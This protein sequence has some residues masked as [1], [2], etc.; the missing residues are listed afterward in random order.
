M[1]IF[2]SLS[3]IVKGAL[4]SSE[5][6]LT[7]TLSALPSAL[8]SVSTT[9]TSITV[10][11]GAST[12]IL[13]EISSLSE[14]LSPILATTARLGISFTESTGVRVQVPSR[15]KILVAAISELSA[16]TRAG[17]AP[18]CTLT[19]ISGVS[20]FVDELASLPS[21]DISSGIRIGSEVRVSDKSPEPVEI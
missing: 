21:I 13:G 19:I 17:V 6:P 8:T 20:S 4:A 9:V 3:L 18:T 10:T 7:V 12:S 16:P 15:F 2:P 1:I 14:L 5:L 11:V